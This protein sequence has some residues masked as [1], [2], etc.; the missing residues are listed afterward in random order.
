MQQLENGLKGTRY[1]LKLEVKQ[2]FDSY[3]CKS[4]HDL[5]LWIESK[6]YHSKIP[7]LLSVTIA[8]STTTPTATATTTMT[9]TVG[10]EKE[11]LLVTCNFVIKIYYKSICHYDLNHDFCLTL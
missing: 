2:V 6:L 7:N 10:N 4:A 8:T 11:H 1:N 9:T 3:Y 5:Y